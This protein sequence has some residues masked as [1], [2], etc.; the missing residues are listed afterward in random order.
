[1][2]CK[3]FESSAKRSV[4]IER[5]ASSTSDNGLKTH[6][7]AQRP[8]GTVLDHSFRCPVAVLIYWLHPS[9]SSHTIT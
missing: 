3:H 9:L 1:M 6:M 4:S 2:K 5:S 7:L 8:W